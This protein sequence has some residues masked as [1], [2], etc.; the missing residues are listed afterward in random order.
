MSETISP[1]E[2]SSVIHRPGLVG[3]RY[4]S[5]S[6]HYSR[7]GSPREHS[8]V[9]ETLTH[10]ATL[11]ADGNQSL[12]ISLIDECRAAIASSAHRRR[13]SWRCIPVVQRSPSG[14]RWREGAGRQ[15]AVLGVTVR[16]IESTVSGVTG[17]HLGPTK[18]SPLC[19]WYHTHEAL[20]LEEHAGAPDGGLGWQLP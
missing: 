6:M 14:S 7:V 15:N 8:C 10:A 20:D 2:S 11:I 12:S 9:M 19:Q 13:Y 16:A 5:Q 17:G 18:G 1:V 4:R 3:Y